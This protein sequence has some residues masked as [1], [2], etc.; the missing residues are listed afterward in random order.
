MATLGEIQD[1]IAS[2]IHR[3]DSGTEILREIRAAV[4]FYASQRFWFNESRTSLTC[5]SGAS[6]YTLS[7]SVISVLAVQ[8]T[9][10]N[11]S[12]TINPISEK[13]RLSYDSNNISGDPSWYAIYGGRF[14]PYPAPNQ[15]YTVGITGIRKPATLSVTGDSNIFTTY[16]ADLIEARATAQLYFRYVQDQEMAAVHKLLEREALMELMRRD[17]QSSPTRIIPTQF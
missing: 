12:Y 15:Q 4:R 8:V 11:T 3:T 7:A 17:T 1:N 9:R 10:N 2:N 13:Q 6:E 14:I 16:A 5:S